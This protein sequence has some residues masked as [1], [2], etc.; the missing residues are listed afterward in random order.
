MMIGTNQ[1]AIQGSSS[2]LQENHDRQRPVLFEEFVLQL[3]PWESD[4]LQH[5]DLMADPHTVAE[6][7]SHGARVVSDGSAWYG[8][9][10]AFGWAMSNDIGERVTVG[11]DPARDAIANSFRSEAYGL[12]AVLRLLT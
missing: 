6:S 10:G 3:E 2:S 8:S 7:I 9:Q 11:M 12:L 1:W 5:T 4:L